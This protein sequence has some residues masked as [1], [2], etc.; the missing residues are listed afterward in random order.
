[1]EGEE[2]KQ[3]AKGPWLEF[4]LAWVAYLNVKL[5][6]EECRK[7]AG[8]GES[9]ICEREKVIAGARKHLRVAEATCRNHSSLRKSGTLERIWANIRAA[10]LA[11]MEVC[12]DEE[13]A[14]RSG[15]LLALMKRHINARSP[16][17]EKVEKSVAEINGRTIGS[18]ISRHDRSVFVGGFKIAYASLDS[19]FRRVRILAT[20][21]WWSTF[22]AVLG[23]VALAFWGAFDTE[24]LDLCFRPQ[25]DLT[26]CPTGAE[27]FVKGKPFTD[28]YADRLDVFTVEV[29][30]LIG[31]AL[32]VITSVRRLH[33]TH[34]HPYHLALAAAVLK[35]PMGAISAL[36]GILFVRGAFVPGL[37]EL[38]SPAQIIG[39]AILF[40]AAQ[41]LVTHII[42]QRAEE[43]ISALDKP[44]PPPPVN[45]GST[46]E[47]LK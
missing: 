7:I 16:Q 15:E 4:P 3:K 26:V 13:V 28:D 18:P 27:E 21:L 24:T 14:A 17:R 8:E 35:F 11:Y 2:G 41:Q 37:S 38:D 40:G 33:D 30:G 19:R 25:P 29:A 31:A 36:V 9:G 22:A 45:S 46:G 1:M 34:S 23:A 10:D 12:S 39:W 6:R 32:T 42:D 43:T 44:P 20:V 5:D 47:P